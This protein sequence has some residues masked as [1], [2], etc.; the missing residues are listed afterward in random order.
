MS[1]EVTSR[2][3]RPLS[4]SSFVKIFFKEVITRVNFSLQFYHGKCDSRAVDPFVLSFVYS[5]LVK[6]TLQEWGGSAQ[7]THYPPCLVPPSWAAL[8][9]LGDTLAG[10]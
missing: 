7:T 6:V 4:T 10:Q 8:A 5:Y 1:N 2:L 3:Y 9:V